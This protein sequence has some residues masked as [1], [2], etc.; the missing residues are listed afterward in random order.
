MCFLSLDKRY[1]L[2]PPII[3]TISHE[4]LKYLTVNVVLE[5]DFLKIQITRCSHKHKEAGE[6][7]A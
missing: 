3:K 7:Y 4:L 2:S 5:G 6:K 1:R